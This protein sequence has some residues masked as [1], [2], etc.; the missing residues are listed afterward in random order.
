ML[1]ITVSTWV[2][3]RGDPIVSPLCPR[4]LKCERSLFADTIALASVTA[5]PKLIVTIRAGA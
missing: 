5:S 4:L 3:L 2:L 1:L